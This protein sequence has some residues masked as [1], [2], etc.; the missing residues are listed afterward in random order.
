MIKKRILS[1]AVCAAMLVSL[2]LS[3]CG[4]DSTKNTWVR[5]TKALGCEQ[6]IT[7][8]NT[9]VPTEEEAK[10]LSEA[11]EELAS[12]LDVS[13]LEAENSDVFNP[14]EVLQ[15]LNTEVYYC[16]TSDME[17][18]TFVCTNNSDETV[19]VYFNLNFKDKDGNTLD[20]GGTMPVIDALGPGET[21]S[22]T[23]IHQITDEPNVVPATIEYKTSL[24]E[25]EKTPINSKMKLS[26]TQDENTVTA[27]IKNKSDSTA[28]GQIDAMYFK[29]DIYVG[30]GRDFFLDGIPAGEEATCNPT[31]IYYNAEW[32]SVEL[33]TNLYEKQ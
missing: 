3:G 27:T 25:S 4:S 5:E 19:E 32:D 6:D 28:Y 14:Y 15:N 8:I 30:Y 16:E 22:A 33:Y 24:H 20:H 9:D 12:Q 23:H 13:K 18:I 29:D 17:Y 2:S 26:Y 7:V 1:L 31:P 10:K 21:S 11:A